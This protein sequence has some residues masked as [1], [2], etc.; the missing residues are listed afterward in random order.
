MTGRG[1]LIVVGVLALLVVGAIVFLQTAPGRSLVQGLVIGQI[2][3]LLADDAEVTAEGLGG[4]FLTGAMLTG[5]EVRRYGE[6]LL[7]VDTLAIDY[8]LTTLLRRTFSA[9]QL[10]VGGPSL[11]VRQR[12]DSTFNVAGLLQPAQDTTG[13]GFAV[14]LDEVA[15]QRGRAEIHWLT[16][17]ARDSVHVVD[18]LRVLVRD[19][20]SR[21]DSL[22]GQIQNLSFR[23]TAPYDAGAALVVADGQFSRDHLRLDQL[24]VT[25][26]AGT[27][28]IG[29]A[30]LAFG[31]DGDLPVFEANVE[32][33]PVALEDAR[34]FAGVAL[35]GD[36]RLRLRADSDGDVLTVSLNGALDDATV[37]LDGEFSRELDGP[38]HYRAEGTLRRFNPAALTHNEALAAEITGDLQ[39]NLQGS[40]LQT[41]SGP[42]NVT[43]R[44]SRAVG[45][46]IDRLT[47]DGSFASGRVS[48]DL[49]GALPGAALQAEG[50]AR[51]FDDV[52]QF[53]VA[54]TAQN[55]DLGLLLPG[56]GR[57][58]TFAGDFALL[59]RGKS[60]DTFSG[61][62]AVNLTRASIDLTTRRLALADADIEA[63]VNRGRVVYDADVTLP[64]GDGRIVAD[65]TLQ[66]GEQPLPFT[67]DGQAFGLN[68]A[69]LTGNPSQESD[70]SGDFTIEARG[71]DIRQSA[72]DL[73][74]DLR[75]SRYGTYDVAAGDLAVQLRRGTARID[76][77]LDLG[78]GGQLTATG[79]ARP[80]DQPLTFDLQGTMRHL[81]LAEVQDLPERYSDLTGTYT[82][83]GAGTD[84][85]TMTLTARVQITEPSS[86]GERFVDAADLAVTLNNGDLTVNG[87]AATP[88]GAFDLAFTGRPFDE[89]Q[90]F[91]FTGTCFTD[92]DVSA[93]A[94]SAPRSDLNGCFSGRIA[95]LGD[96]ATADGEGVV[97]LRPSTIN[98][99]EIDE[100]RVAFTLT[101]GALGA[102]VDATLA[103]PPADEGVSEGGRVVAAVQGRPFD[104]VP[105]F[106]IRGRT[107]ALDVGAL[108]DLPPDQPLRVSLEYDLDL[109]GTDPAT[110][111]LSGSLTGGG[112]TLGPVRLD[113]LRTQF[114]LEDG[115][116]RVDTLVFDSDVAD[117][118][119]G[120]TLALFND[121]AASSF[122]LS[123]DVESLA[124]V[125]SYT[126]QTL[127]LE[128]GTF[129]LAVTAEPNAP[130]R[131][132]GSL[133][134]RQ[135]VVGGYAVTGLDGALN[136]TWD[137]SLPDSLGLK[138]LN[139]RAVAAFD[140]L[141][142]PRFIVEKGETT[143][144]A[145][146]GEFTVSGEVTVD[147]RR[148][149]EFFARLEAETDPP[150]VVL[151]RGRFSLDATTWTLEQPA[152][153]ALEEDGID[154]RGL[155]LTSDVGGQQI[156]ADGQIDFNGEQSFIVTV[157]DVQIGGLTDLVN[158]DALGGEL[159]ATLVLT[160]P[161]SAPLIDGTVELDSFTSRGE[162]V[163]ALAA[164][165]DYADNRLIIDAVLTH[166][167]GQT[168]TVDGSV[169]FQFSLA[170]V[171]AEEVRDDAQVNLVARA[172]SFPIAWA[173]PFLDERTYNDLGGALR[174]DLTVTGT[175]GNPRLD[176]V[177]S[178]S[179]G[180]LGVTATGRTYEPIQAD[181]TFQ[182]DRLV[183]DDVRILDETGRTALDITGAVRFREL[184]VGELNLTITPRDFV[185]MDTRTFRGLTV[186]RGST[187]LR[188]TGTL[189]QPV[190]RGSVVLAQGD[191]YLTDELAP[192]ELDPV[193]LTDAQIREVE[194]RF[195][196]VVTARD[197]AVSRF[198]DALDYN[199]TV[200]IRRNVWLRSQGAL[201]FDIEFEGDVQAIKG[202]YAE[203]SRLY[204][205]V[206]LVRGTVKPFAALN[207]RFDIEGGTLTFNG[208]PL[209]AE[210]DFSATSE[211]NIAG[212]VSGQSSVTVTLTAAG[213]FNNN[214]TFRLTS[215]PTLEQAD[216]ISLIATGRLA[217]EGAG[218]LVGGVTQVGIGVASGLF[219][220]FANDLS[221]LD[222]Q[223]DFDANGAVVVRLGR[224]L[225]ERAFVT[226]GYAYDAAGA[227]GRSEDSGAVFTL[228]YAIRQWLA[229][230]GEI[231]VSPTQGVDPGGGLSV[232]TSW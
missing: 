159:S 78:P 216:I 32:A 151:E 128:R 138:A 134:A 102:T 79:T 118:A 166:V 165:V 230:Q 107:E 57:S 228:D 226:V 97:T 6:T 16:D 152:R 157:E 210:L 43:L 155:L 206:D 93:F 180:R 83:Q 117:L 20:V 33:T 142:T 121:A 90:A 8:N 221:G 154:V 87:T 201:P 145:Q 149:L 194:A 123:G 3:N 88:E 214:P 10:Y 55:V 36:P 80:F 195:G 173:R 174:L 51:P 29:A 112:S 132:I 100:G 115:V 176:G 63:T 175:Q 76:A 139:G 48:F 109:R 64:G 101:D 183:L 220:G 75:G 181:V 44:E 53:Q 130:L 54:G 24:R 224:Y 110:M 208:D 58:D 158:L 122:R 198:T 89:R 212:S 202:P 30:R 25:S 232:E 85:A 108:L 4:N 120:G 113:T 187:P 207:R 150:A 124:P 211:V 7:R 91:A 39:L 34:A 81:D 86:Y 40:T 23:A 31:A 190:L 205:A 70:L 168:L 136:A 17:G 199:L 231:Q 1:A 116:V 19:F 184:S 69:A 13:G 144:A 223:V 197:T 15:L 95:G 170:P 218:T 148:D 146:A 186:S 222:L 105:S 27:N 153:I 131:I 200:E 62:V 227:G 163:G 96:L 106:S 160:G 72:I 133:D 45:R 104:E 217:S 213:Q 52:P 204:G 73:T 42:F 47:V 35:Y 71:L 177:A 161:A 11:Y 94:P 46:R 172:D 77:D 9:S 56:S 192:P 68:L 189:D 178:L 28:V 179:N 167:S 164:N 137:R 126:E 50:T 215:N 65:G 147:D 141:S 59:G 74:A 82:A 127:G 185:A 114:A 37:S 219:E 98:E 203:S 14:L 84:P 135:L 5:L 169:P 21:E 162:T 119:G 191:I 38:V 12:A 26:R 66:L 18:S 188:L 49:N 143:V 225:T 111:L 129:A 2:E 41:L 125:A 22:V 61:N 103:S 171:P 229:A 196:R 67:A 140:V 182:N 193:A 156:A 99:A 60:L 209:G 92:L